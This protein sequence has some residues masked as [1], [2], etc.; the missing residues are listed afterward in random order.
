MSN[1]STFLAND[2]RQ[3]FVQPAPLHPHA[4]RLDHHLERAVRRMVRRVI[5]RGE[6]AS[7]VGDRVMAAAESLIRQS[8]LLR[9]DRQRL[10][11][12]VARRLCDLLR[13]QL[14]QERGHLLGRR[15]TGSH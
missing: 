5:R 13:L 12:R 15:V 7:F 14:E 1:I 10:T 3:T 11:G 6:A 9:I 8:S 2:L 4:G